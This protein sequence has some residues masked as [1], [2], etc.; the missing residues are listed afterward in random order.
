M[1]WMHLADACR[2]FSQRPKVP[3]QIAQEIKKIWR[4][5]IELSKTCN[6]QKKSRVG[7]TDAAS[8]AEP[9]W[10]G[11]KGSNYPPGVLKSSA[12]KEWPACFFA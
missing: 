12:G 5:P 8:F 3:Q 11:I 4:K 2:F 9:P 1:R 10:Q 7:R 6:A